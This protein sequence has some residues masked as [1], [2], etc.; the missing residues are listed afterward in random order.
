M[1]TCPECSRKLRAYR[2]ALR[3]AKEQ[4][5]KAAKYCEEG[6]CP[7]ANP[8]FTLRTLCADMLAFVEAVEWSGELTNGHLVAACCPVCRGARSQAE[9][10]MLT[11]R[12]GHTPSCLFPK[13]KARLEAARGM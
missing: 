1:N 11:R 12:F 7:L 10:F 3:L 6:R 9:A 13:L 8:Y 4:R 2:K 5:R